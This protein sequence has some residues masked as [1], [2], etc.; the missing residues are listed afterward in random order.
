MR[1]LPFN[2]SGKGSHWRALRQSRNMIWPLFIQDPF[3]FCGKEML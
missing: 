2:L 1:T 3:S